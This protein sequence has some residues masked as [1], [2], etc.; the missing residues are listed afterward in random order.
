MDE[1]ILVLPCTVGHIGGTQRV[2]V[3]YKADLSL[4][5]KHETELDAN[6]RKSIKEEMLRN[7]RTKRQI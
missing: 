4:K 2:K 7:Q 3:C 1:R 5:R 6:H